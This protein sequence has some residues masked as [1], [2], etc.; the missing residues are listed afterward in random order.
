V[1][2]IASS[3]RFMHRYLIPPGRRAMTTCLTI[4]GY[5]PIR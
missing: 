4:R 3:Y 5:C 1:L 2:K